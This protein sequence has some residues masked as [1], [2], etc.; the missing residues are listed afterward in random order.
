MDGIP[1]TEI[2][3]L[4]CP[5]FWEDAATAAAHQPPAERPHTCRVYSV[6]TSYVSIRKGETTHPDAGGVDGRKSAGRQGCGQ[7]ALDILVSIQPA[8]LGLSWACIEG[9]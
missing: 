7:V 3:A 4:T 2:N 5:T 1:Y 8:P 9:K 6:N